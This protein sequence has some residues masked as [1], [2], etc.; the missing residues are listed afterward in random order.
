LR[1]LAVI[2]EHALWTPQPS[3]L[4][5]SVFGPHAAPLAAHAHASDLGHVTACWLTSAGCSDRAIESEGVADEAVGADIRADIRVVVQRQRLVGRDRRKDPPGDT[6][7]VSPR[8][9]VVEGTCTNR[10]FRVIL[11][12]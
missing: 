6:R 4:A 10:L 3:G 12:K 8:E 2:S 7:V 9:G 5:P 11:H 1:L